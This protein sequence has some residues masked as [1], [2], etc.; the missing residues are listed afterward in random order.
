MTT[1][2][3]AATFPAWEAQLAAQRGTLNG[4]LATAR[5]AGASAEALRSAMRELGP[6]VETLLAVL[7]PSRADAVCRV[8][9]ELVCDLVVRKVW[10]ERSAERWAVL[11]VLPHLPRAVERSPRTAVEVVVLGAARIARETDLR[12]WGARLAAADALLTD[13]A[14]LRAGAAVAAWRSGLVRVRRSAHA[15][16]A[17]LGP[18]ADGAAPGALTAL[19]GLED[20]GVSAREALAVNAIDPFSW[21]GA[22]DRGTVATYGG[23]RAFGGPWTGVP[24]VLEPVDAWTPTWRVLADGIP[25]VVVAD[26]HGHAVLREPAGA[27]RSAVGAPRADLVRDVRSHVAWE[28]DV[29]GAAAAGPG[30]TGA[31]PVLVSRATSCRLDL[32]L[33]PAEDRDPVPVGGSDR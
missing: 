1:V 20:S 6:T 21:P 3:S 14:A 10:H 5:G 11:S 32:V 7:A 15:A 26:V 12:A 19:L 13:D 24:V 9:T 28:D 2:P 29:T 33:V 23:Y 31:R 27:Q 8:L 4:I 17:T 16:A 25:W 22:P 30:A 18:G